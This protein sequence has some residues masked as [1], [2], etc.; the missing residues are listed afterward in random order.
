MTIVALGAEKQ[1]ATSLAM[2]YPEAEVLLVSD[3]DILDGAD[4]GNVRMVRG[5]I[6]DGPR[7]TEK[8]DRVVVLCPRWIP[9]PPALSEMMPRIER[10]FPG[11]CLPVQRKP[12][13]GGEWIVKG[14]LWHRPDAPVVGDPAQLSDLTDQHGCGV[15]YQPYVEATGCVMTIGRR[16]DAGAV[17]MGV[18]EVF[19]ERYFR[20]AV[21]QAGETIDAPALRDASLDVLDALDHRGYF[22]LNWLRTA[23]GDRLSSV[24]PVPRAAFAALLKGGV[25]LLGTANGVTVARPGIRFIANPHYTSFRRLVA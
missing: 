11:R 7:F 16:D 14:D 1:A 23:D 10:A 2:A 9:Q 12:P 20:D 5:D 17:S 3:S 15:V 6:G 24:R 18:I 22:T 4:L 21:L 8:A 19:E 25:D 13:A